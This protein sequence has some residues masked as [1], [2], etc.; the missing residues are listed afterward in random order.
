MV[1]ISHS[2]KDKDFV[3]AL[4]NLLEDIGLNKILCFVALL[5]DMVWN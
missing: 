2:S 1:F 5:L 4:V 3:E